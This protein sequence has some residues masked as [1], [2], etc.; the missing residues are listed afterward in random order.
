ML[1]TSTLAVAAPIVHTEINV[2]PQAP[3]TPVSTGNYVGGA[4]IVVILAVMLV[5]GLSAAGIIKPRKAA[6][7]ALSESFGSSH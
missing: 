5:A 6:K 1:S 2:T 3:T 7:P 4:A